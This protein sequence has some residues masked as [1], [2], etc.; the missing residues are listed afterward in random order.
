M[1]GTPILK[2]KKVATRQV[3][4]GL[5]VKNKNKM[6]SILGFLLYLKEN[7]KIDETE[8][9]RLME[10]LPLYSISRIQTEFLEQDAFDLKKVEVELWKPMVVENKLNKKAEKAEKKEKPKKERKVKKTTDD[11]NVDENVET[12]K[13]GR[14]AKKQIIEFNNNITGTVTC[15]MEGSSDQLEELLN[16]M[17]ETSDEEKEQEL[18]EVNE[19]DLEAVLRELEEG[20]LE[21]ENMVVVPVVVPVP[22][23][24]PPT[25]KATKAKPEK[26]EKG[27]GGK[28]DKKAEEPKEEGE[29]EEEKKIEEKK[30]TTEEEKKIEEKK[31]TTTNKKDKK[32]VK[33]SE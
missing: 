3:S 4:K 2:E 11:E 30:V 9:K 17:L 31:V 1:A 15:D 21:E 12:K 22:I 13:R 16:E 32:K 26:A 28:K 5:S 29:E 23:V 7:G 8:A 14:K 33:I 25:K 10:E 24:P 20:E 19:S 27:K 6:C 18:K